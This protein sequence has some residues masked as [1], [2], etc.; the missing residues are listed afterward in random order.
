MSRKLQAVVVCFLASGLAMQSA[1]AVPG[2]PGGRSRRGSNS[3]TVLICSG[4]PLRKTLHV[5]IS[6]EEVAFDEYQSY[7]VI[8]YLDPSGKMIPGSRQN[9]S[10]RPTYSQRA[11][12]PVVWRGDGF[13]L[14][15]SRKVSM[16]SGN[17]PA[18]LLAEHYGARINEELTCHK[19]R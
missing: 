18:T 15:A 9:T 1:S 6:S 5:Q 7:G 16:P 13:K 14:T 10:V 8:S 12:G 3:K 2:K 17:L 4:K 11:D 19:P